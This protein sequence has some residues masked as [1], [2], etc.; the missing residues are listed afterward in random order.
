MRQLYPNI[1]I[2]EGAFTLPSRSK[3]QINYRMKNKGLG[4][5]E[6]MDVKLFLNYTLFQEVQFY[7][8]GNQFP[9]KCSTF[10]C[11]VVIPSVDPESE[12]DVEI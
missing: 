12:H 9:T 2:S 5:M 3:A 4:L 10:E 7:V 6:N 8:D 1:W 11:A